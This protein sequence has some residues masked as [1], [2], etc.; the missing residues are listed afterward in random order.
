MPSDGMMG[1][2]GPAHDDEVEVDS[3]FRETLV[4]VV[5]ECLQQ[6]PEGVRTDEYFEEHIEPILSKL[7]VDGL[8]TQ[9]EHP[10][11]FVKSWADQQSQL[12]FMDVS[13]VSGDMPQ[14]SPIATMANLSWRQKKTEGELDSLRLRYELLT[15]A[16]GRTHQGR[17]AVSAAEKGD[18]QGVFHALEQMS[19]SGS[20]GVQ[21]NLWRSPDDQSMS[22]HGQTSGLSIPANRSSEAANEQLGAVLRCLREQGITSASSAFTYF[23]PDQDSAVPGQQMLEMIQRMG[24]LRSHE[25]SNLLDSLDPTGCGKVH[26]QNFRTAVVG[27]LASSRDFHSALSPEEFHAI[28]YR[29][30]KRIQMKGQSLSQFFSEWG[31]NQNGFINTGE[32]LTGL[33]SLRLGLSGKEVAQIFNSLRAESYDSGEGGPLQGKMV[34]LEAFKM[35][36]EQ[37]AQDVRLKDWAT[38]AFARLRERITVKAVEQHADSEAPQHLDYTSFVTFL[39]TSDPAMTPPEIGRLWCLLD[40]EDS[41]ERPLVRLEEVLRWLEPQEPSLHS[42]MR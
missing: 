5:N 11:A 30:Q 16:L 40:K 42:S 35:L 13:N 21:G 4:N 25:A 1:W 38:G 12:G 29:I 41:F 27:F 7:A 24:V 32:F 17:E 28:M 31:A 23:R 20:A 26:Y 10:A 18:R 15:Q 39:S 36:V 19:F 3:A 37:G 8:R 14:T 33:R 6:K 22:R 2:G 34:N 9:P